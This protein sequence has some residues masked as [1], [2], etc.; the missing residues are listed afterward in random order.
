VAS[1]RRPRPPATARGLP[2]P[3]SKMPRRR[4]NPPLPNRPR[5]LRLSR[6]RLSRLRR[7]PRLPN[8]RRPGRHPA[9]SAQDQRPAR[10]R[11]RSRQLA[12]RASAT[13]RSRPHSRW[14]GL[15]RV[16]KHRVPVPPVL[17]LRAQAP[18]Q[19]ACRPVPLAGPVDKAG[20]HVPAAHRDPGPVVGQ[21]PRRVAAPAAAVGTIAAGA[22]AAVR[23][24]PRPAAVVVV[25]A[26]VQGVVAAVAVPVSAV[27]LPARSAVPAARRGA[28][29]SPSGRNAPSTRTCRRR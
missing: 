7:R 21:V 13:T 3:P 20:H 26:A 27:G 6:L 8:S 28:V 2:K 18:H 23:S 1:P 5:R 22:P 12:R 15:F 14:T 29:A 11:P 10:A 17:A 4:K 9:R 19:A 24:V 25:S 16:R